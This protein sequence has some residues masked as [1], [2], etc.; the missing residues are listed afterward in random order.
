MRNNK[1]VIPP[2]NLLI[3]QA[4]EYFWRNE[5][6]IKINLPKWEKYNEEY[7]LKNKDKFKI[8]ENSILVMFTWRESK[9]NFNADISPFY[10]ENISRIL[11]NDLLNDALE[12][13][14]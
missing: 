3:E 8:D 11:E 4:R 6:I 5:D 14:I 9:K 1:I 2:S 13:K 7:Q 10:H 12:R